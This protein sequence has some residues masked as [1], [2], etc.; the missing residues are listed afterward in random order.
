M[1]SSVAL[2]SKLELTQNRKLVKRLKLGSI[3]INQLDSLEVLVIPDL[4]F[5]FF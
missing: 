1:Q 5:K 3:Q 4:L 2:I